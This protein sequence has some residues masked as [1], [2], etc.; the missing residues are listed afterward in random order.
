[1]IFLKY[2]NNN[3]NLAIFWLVRT[4]ITIAP[5]LSFVYSFNSKFDFCVHKNKYSCPHI[6]CTY[7]PSGKESRTS[8]LF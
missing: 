7:V 8:L 2:I 6:G 5:I 4:I 3:F 1:M